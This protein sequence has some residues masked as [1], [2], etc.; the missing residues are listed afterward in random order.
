MPDIKLHHTTPVLACAD[1][2]EALALCVARLGF[3]R[4]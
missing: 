4:E 2:E 3:R 1:I